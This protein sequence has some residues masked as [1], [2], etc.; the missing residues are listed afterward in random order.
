MILIF[1]K[2]RLES[3]TVFS[4]KYSIIRNNC[5]FLWIHKKIRNSKARYI[6]YT[7]Y[8]FPLQWNWPDCQKIISYKTKYWSSITNISLSLA[9]YVDF[10][11]IVDEQL[12]TD[13]P[14][15]KI[16]WVYLCWLDFIWNETKHLWI[17]TGWKLYQNTNWSFNRSYKTAIY[18]LY[19]FFRYVYMFYFVSMKTQ[20]FW[21]YSINW[22]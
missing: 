6:L 10:F 14:L 20:F 17:V 1:S 11:D 13:R 21:K 8:K 9:K 12:I 19:I 4:W 5:F 2:Y 3:M 15:L 18:I 16:R 22:N 7:N